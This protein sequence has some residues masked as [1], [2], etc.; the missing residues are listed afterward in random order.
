LQA[1][2]ASGFSFEPQ[3]NGAHAREFQ[4]V[5]FATQSAVALAVVGQRVIGD[6]LAFI[7]G[8]AG[9]VEIDGGSGLLLPLFTG[10]GPGKLR[11]DVRAAEICVALVGDVLCEIA[12]PLQR[13]QSRSWAAPAAQRSRGARAAVNIK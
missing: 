2:S 6:V 7:C 9:T 8:H 12:K 13:R 5:H 4:T 1:C 10:Q 3:E 11:E